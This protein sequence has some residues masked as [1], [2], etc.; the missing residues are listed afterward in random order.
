[1]PE[2][3]NIALQGR[4]TS[5]DSPTW[6]WAETLLVGDR[7]VSRLY[8]IKFPLLIATSVVVLAKYLSGRDAGS[9]G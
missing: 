4:K 3:Q 7:K 8:N 6:K 2:T 5:D 9:L 1:L